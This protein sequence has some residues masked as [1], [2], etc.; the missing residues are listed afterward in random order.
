MRST[1]AHR[2][3]VAAGAVLSA[4]GAALSAYA[5]H[6]ASGDA[7]ERLASAA[8]FALLHGIA[9]AALPRQTTR[10][11]GLLALAMLLFGAVLFCGALVGAHA[12]GW[13]TRLA[14]V[15]GL[16]IILGWLLYAVD[17]IRR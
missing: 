1:F 3:L 6:G 9:L 8:L 14:P 13:S 12:F 7:R 11:I 15:G 5:A 2:G 4:F 10:R 16:S 17:A